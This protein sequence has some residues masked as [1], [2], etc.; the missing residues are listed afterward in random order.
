MLK[1]KVHVFP[2]SCF[3]SRMTLNGG[4]PAGLGACPNQNFIKFVL[5]LVECQQYMIYP[6]ESQKAVDTTKG[7][8]C[9]AAPTTAQ[10]HCLPS[11]RVTTFSSKL[12]STWLSTPHYYSDWATH[13]TWLGFELGISQSWRNALLSWLG[14]VDFLDLLAGIAFAPLRMCIAVA[15]DFRLV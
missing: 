2:E 6:H 10:S 9:L 4:W 1:H 8:W 3:I 11:P 12:V 14:L 13:C 15:Y 7:Q 5:I